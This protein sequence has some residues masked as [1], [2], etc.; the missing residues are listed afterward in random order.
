MNSH[1]PESKRYIDARTKGRPP[2]RDTRVLNEHVVDDVEEAM[3]GN[4]GS[5]EQ[6]VTQGAEHG[7]RREREG[8]HQLPQE[9]VA[10]T[11]QD[12]E[13]NVVERDD[14]ENGWIETTVAIESR[15]F[16]KNGNRNRE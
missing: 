12:G 1:H 13:E 16:A 6:R 3:P 14:D 10:G 2:G 7:D 5:D 4:A 11:S 8:D 9:R 15:D